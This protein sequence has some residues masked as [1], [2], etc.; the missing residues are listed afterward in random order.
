MVVP[1][2]KDVLVGVR[3]RCVLVLYGTILLLAA[4][5]ASQTPEFVEKGT[6]HTSES[7]VR[8]LD[9]NG[10]GK[11]ADASIDDAEDLRRD[12]LAALRR[13]G[14]AGREAADLITRTFAAAPRGVP[15][16]VERADFDGAEAWLV[17]EA[18]PAADGR[19]GERRLW[20]LDD[21]GRILFFSSR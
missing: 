9:S 16:R 8:A 10:P 2:R 1:E 19:L 17:L 15:Y 20:V 21:G 12:A 5:C 6:A 3:I 11:L 7:A 14:E 4:G 18:V 13:R